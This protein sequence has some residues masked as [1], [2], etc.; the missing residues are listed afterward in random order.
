MRIDEVRRCAF[1]VSRKLR[2]ATILNRASGKSFYGIGIRSSGTWKNRGGN[3]FSLRLLEHVYKDLYS[4]I[5]SYRVAIIQIQN[6]V[7]EQEFLVKSDIGQ[8]ERSCKP[9][10]KR[11]T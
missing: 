7:L 6:P 11:R 3:V 8:L 5:Y 1:E 2:R 4:K 9:R 10:F